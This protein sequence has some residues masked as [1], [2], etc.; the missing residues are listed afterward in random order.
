MQ[1]N[2]K[3]ISC[4]KDNDQCY[5]MYSWRNYQSSYGMTICINCM[6]FAKMILKRKIYYHKQNSLN[7]LYSKDIPRYNLNKFLYYHRV[8]LSTL[9]MCMYLRIVH[10]LEND[11]L[12]K[13]YFEEKS[14]HY[15]KD[16]FHFECIKCN[17]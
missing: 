15:I 12:N 5:K 9:D 17:C 13:H 11:F 14:Y 16:I 8:Q 10:N 1:D 3:H 2:N 6:L 4:W 7:Y